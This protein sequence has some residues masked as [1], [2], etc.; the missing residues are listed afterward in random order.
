MW[1]QKQSPDAWRFIQN[2]W[3]LTGPGG[4]SSLCKGFQSDSTQSLSHSQNYSAF[5]ENAGTSLA[6]T[7]VHIQENSPGWLFLG[8]LGCRRGRSLEV[9]SPQ[10]SLT[11]TPARVSSLTRARLQPSQTGTP[12]RCRVSL[13]GFR[14]QDRRISPLLVSEAPHERKKKKV[15]S[16]FCSTTLPLWSWVEGERGWVRSQEWSYNPLSKWDILENERGAINSYT[17]ITDVKQEYLRQTRMCGHP[18]KYLP[19]LLQVRGLL[20]GWWCPV[21]SQDIC[22]WRKSTF[23]IE[24]KPHVASSLVSQEQKKK[25]TQEPQKCGQG[26]YLSSSLLH[27]LGQKWL[28]FSK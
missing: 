27:L 7:L 14:E 22:Q 12:Q 17:R 20:L 4:S 24:P 16:T 23:Q 10:L 8:S 19:L 1:T 18:R 6:S 5:H 11:C 21:P 15:T 26:P 9:P 3:S 2:A 13:A 28:V 25:Q